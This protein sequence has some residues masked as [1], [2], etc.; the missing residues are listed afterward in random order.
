MATKKQAKAT[1]NKTNKEKDYEVI[2]KRSGRL[3]VKNNAGKYVNGP[4]KIALL[5]KEGL[6]KAPGPGK[7]AKEAAAAAAAAA[8]PA[9]PEAPKA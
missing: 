2:T 8:T 5:V 1:T 7:K 3:A 6:M 9:A 4:D